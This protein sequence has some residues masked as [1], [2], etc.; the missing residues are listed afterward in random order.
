MIYLHYGSTL[1]RI[2]SLLIH[3]K[4]LESYLDQKVFS[5]K[6]L[7]SGG[8][9]ENSCSDCLKY[10]SLLEALNY[11]FQSEESSTIELPD[12]SY[13]LNDNLLSDFWKAQSNQK[14]IFSVPKGGKI[15]TISIFGNY[16]TIEIKYTKFLFVNNIFSI[17]L[18]NLE[19]KFQKIYILFFKVHLSLI[20]NLDVFFVC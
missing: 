16:E 19:M 11:S 2:F 13:L 9:M 15:K 1:I 5:K 6:L 8:N 10:T 20:Y 12:E 4:I 18:N 3:L 14:I 17:D 7:V